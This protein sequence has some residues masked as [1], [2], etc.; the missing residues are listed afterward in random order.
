M[1]QTIK[2]LGS[3][4]YQCIGV[5]QSDDGINL[6]TENCNPGTVS[7]NWN[8]DALNGYI[9]NQKWTSMPVCVTEDTP[10]GL[11]SLEQ[12]NGSKEQKWDYTN[13]DIINRHSKNCL[14]VDPHRFNDYPNIIT[15][16]CVEDVKFNSDIFE[17]KTEKEKMQLKSESTFVCDD[18]CAFQTNLM[19]IISISVVAAVAILTGSGILTYNFVKR[20]K[21]N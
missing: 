10:G 8:Y 6:V 21:K 12:C 14:G 7:H 20:H 17:G 4:K 18:A 3:G 13:G 16:P 2:V 11:V 15:L 5:S 1:D 9:T 19:I